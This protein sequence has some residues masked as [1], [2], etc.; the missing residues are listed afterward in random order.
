MDTKPPER[1]EVEHAAKNYSRV[2]NMLVDGYM[3]LLP[4][5]KWLFVCLI[6]LCG[7]EGTR[8]LSLRYICQQT[9]FSLGA[10][11]PNKKK[12]YPG[13][14]QKLHDAGL[15][16]A[17]IKKR[18]N[19]RGQ[20]TGN[21][22]YHI[23]ITDTWNLNYN[24]Y[25]G[26]NACSTVERVEGESESPVLQSNGPVLQ[27]NGLG[28][29]CSTVEQTCSTFQ[30]NIRLQSKITESN[31]I[32]EQETCVTGQ[33]SLT[34]APSGADTHALSLS[35]S[36]REELESPA[37]DQ[38]PDPAHSLSHSAPSS[39]VP[40]GNAAGQQALQP[41]VD[42]PSLIVSTPPQ[43]QPPKGVKARSPGHSGNTL[44]DAGQTV[45][46][47]WQEL[48]KNPIPLTDGLIKAANQLGPCDPSVEDLH[49]VEKHCYATDKTGYFK[50]G[51]KLWDIAREWEGWQSVK[52]AGHHVT[53]QA[54]AKPPTPGNSWEGMT[55]EEFQK[56]FYP[57]EALRF[58]RAVAQNEALRQQ[59]QQAAVQ[60][61]E[62]K[63]VNATD[64]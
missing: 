51:V 13:M 21:E 53:Q 11:A 17:E 36:H 5:E 29:E 33:Q 19:A 47:R 41:R 18:K 44:S 64:W 50:R 62:R 31:K 63:I 22:Q 1:K 45:L 7:K 14:I 57:P 27:S 12:S 35:S 49:A 20:E 3:H 30:T 8:F 2:P 38:P 46:N 16:H 43:R 61:P 39:L 59:Q 34:V 9:G 40:V 42:T 37:N 25:Y 23:T 56:E 6:R 32:T 54:S 28:E 48:R 60:V 15:I 4:Q 55:Q 10:L 52:A 24:F 58:K 26:D